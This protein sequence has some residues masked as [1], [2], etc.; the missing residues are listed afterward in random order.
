MVQKLLNLKQKIL[1]IAA[2]RLCLGNIS[3]YFSADNM[4]NTELHG[5]GYDF[6]VNYEAVAVDDILEIRKYSMKKNN[7]I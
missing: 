4:K 1:K 6:S 3:K 5:C 7:I 2:T